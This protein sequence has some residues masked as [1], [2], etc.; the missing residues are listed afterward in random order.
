MIKRKSC[1]MSA[2][3]SRIKMRRRRELWEKGCICRKASPHRWICSVRNNFRVLNL[4]DSVKSFVEASTNIHL[5]EASSSIP[6]STQMDSLT[7]SE[8]CGEAGTVAPSP[9]TRLSTPEQSG[10]IGARGPP[11]LSWT[12]WSEE[13][14]SGDPTTPRPLPSNPARTNTKTAVPPVPH[15][16][17][18]RK[19]AISW[20][21]PYL[22]PLSSGN[23][24]LRR[25][26]AERKSKGGTCSETGD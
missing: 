5:L 22:C 17:T 14:T 23:I 12:P 4:F 8:V 3:T 11:G 6:S 18:L 2:V 24:S 10:A 19:K 7:V 1:S 15:H 20:D 21:S 26:Q 25:A 9:Q 16:Q 13:G